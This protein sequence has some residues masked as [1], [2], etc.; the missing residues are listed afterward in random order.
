[1]KAANSYLKRFY[2]NNKG[3]TLIEAVVAIAMIGMVSVGI[4]TFMFSLSKT[5]KMSE[6]VLKVNAICSVVRENVVQ[7][8]RNNTAIFGNESTGEKAEGIGTTHTE[9]IVKDQS[10]VEYPEYNF[11]LYCTDETDYGDPGKK[12]RRYRII[13][14]NS[15]NNVLADF[16]TDVYP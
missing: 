12:V 4:T 7:S 10:G 1:L 15:N 8:A 11:D 2:K 6:E 13:I 9:L 14:K 5:T 16:F 3:L